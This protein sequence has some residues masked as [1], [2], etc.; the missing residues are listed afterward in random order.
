MA[1]NCDACTPDGQASPLQRS[2]ALLLTPTFESV[3]RLQMLKFGIPPPA[4]K[5]KMQQDG[6]NPDV[7]DCDPTK[8]LPKRF[9]SQEDQL[10]AFID[11]P[12]LKDEPLYKKYFQVRVLLADAIAMTCML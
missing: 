12:P 9:V 2:V 8:P 7:L 10:E 1:F 6:L 4:V 3:L 11:G 5:L